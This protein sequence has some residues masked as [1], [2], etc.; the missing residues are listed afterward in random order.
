MILSPVTV[1]VV[2]DEP[3]LCE[4]MVDELKTLGFI[5]LRATTGEEAL[6]LIA[7]DEPVDVL[8]TDIRLPGALDGWDVAEKFRSRNPSGPV[9]YTTG[10]TGTP[11]RRVL[12]ERLHAEALSPR[13][14]RQRDPALERTGLIRPCSS[15]RGRKGGRVG[16]GLRV[17]LDGVGMAAGLDVADHPHQE[18]QPHR[19]ERPP[20]ERSG[21]VVGVDEA[22]LL[23]RDRAFVHAVGEVVDR[24]AGDRIAAFHRPL[25]RRDAAVPRQER[26]VI[27]DR[28]FRRLGARLRRD[29]GVG[30]GRQHHVDRVRDVGGDDPARAAEHD[31]RHAGGAGRG[32]E[33]VFLL[34]PDDRE[35][36]PFLAEKPEHLRPE[37]ARSDQCDA[38]VLL[39]SSRLLL[40]GPGGGSSATGYSSFPIFFVTAI[41]RALSASTNFA[42]SGASW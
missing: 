28:G 21:V 11:V 22:P 6:N 13:R 5:V 17:L 3:L 30:M 25:D 29:E 19:S 8:F 20:P 12:A 10:Y 40:P 35:V 31:E 27:A 38:H 26:R 9:I 18:P 37:P 15:L 2:E 41:R 23:R 33:L 42:K 24:A 36:V 14:D 1:L 32:R 34:E 16:D 4:L 7:G 39:P